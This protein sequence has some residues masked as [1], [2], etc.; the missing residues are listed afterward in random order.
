MNWIVRADLPTPPPPTTT[1][2]Y[3]SCTEPSF[4]PA[5]ED[6]SLRSPP[7]PPPEHQWA[8]NTH[9]FSPPS[10]EE[11]F[12]GRLEGWTKRAQVG[13][14]KHTGRWTPSSA[15]LDKRGVP[16]PYACPCFSVNNAAVFELWTRRKEW[17]AGAS[18]GVCRKGRLSWSC[19][20]V[21]HTHTR[22]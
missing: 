1:S 5:I 14:G 10:S 21:T 20:C 17:S 2:R 8:A 7:P 18:T 19:T 16:S 13:G 12:C 15:R 3:F 22:T 9:F 6:T 11:R 4:Q